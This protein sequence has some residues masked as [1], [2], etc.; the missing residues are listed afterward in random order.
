MSHIINNEND[1][2]TVSKL[3]EELRKKGYCKTVLEEILNSII[4][5]NNNLPIDVVFGNSQIPAFFNGKKI[6]ISIDVLKNYI[7]KKLNLYYKLYPDLKKEIFYNHVLLTL[8][9]EVEHYYQRLI[10][11]KYIDFPY[12]IIIESYKNLDHLIIPKDSNII[13]ALIKFKKFSSYSKRPDS[14]LERN[15]NVESYDLLVK[16]ANYESNKEMLKILD[17]LLSFTLTLGYRWFNNGSIEK[18]YRKKG[19]TDIYNSFN[20]D[21]IIPIEDKVRYGLPIDKQT[22]KKVLNYQF[23]I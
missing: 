3:L 1:I 15:A 10:A 23:K 12:K 18:T 5:K 17:E 11:N 14:L 22:K 16:V 19:M 6:E 13:D 9:H 8:S 21:E 20:H 4:P 7:D 2:K